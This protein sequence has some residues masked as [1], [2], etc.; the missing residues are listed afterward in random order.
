M[1]ETAALLSPSE[2][3]PPNRRDCSDD[4][5]PDLAD[6]NAR[7][8]TQMLSAKSVAA[9]PYVGGSVGK[10]RDLRTLRR[11]R[12]SRRGPQFLKIGGRFFYTIEALREFYNRSIRGGIG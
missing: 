1:I 4:S 5:V 11:W 9:S 10:P 3:V 6:W 7:P 2:P 12:A 8:K